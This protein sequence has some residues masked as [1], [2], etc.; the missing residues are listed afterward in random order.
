MHLGAGEGTKCLGGEMD[1]KVGSEGET[2]FG[3]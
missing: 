3:R 2:G 1:L